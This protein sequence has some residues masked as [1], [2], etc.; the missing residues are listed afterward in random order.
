MAFLSCWVLE[1]NY[2]SWPYFLHHYPMSDMILTDFHGKLRVSS[3]NWPV[4]V[5]VVVNTG[6]VIQV[7]KLVVLCSVHYCHWF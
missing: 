6:M 7:F 3:M 2:E 4:H 5:M 1:L